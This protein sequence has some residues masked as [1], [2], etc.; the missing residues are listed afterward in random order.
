MNETCVLVA[1]ALATA[2]SLQ[3]GSVTRRSGPHPEVRGREVLRGRQGGQ[4]RLPD[5]A[6]VVRG[7]VAEGRAEGRLDLHAQGHLRAAGRRQPA[8]EPRLIELGGGGR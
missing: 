7:H 8:V 4:E 6:L 1:S 3:L 5:L 2:L